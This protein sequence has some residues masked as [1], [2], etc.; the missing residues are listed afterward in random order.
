MAY[1]DSAGNYVEVGGLLPDR[2][3][4]ALVRVEP[5]EVGAA[6]QVVGAG[7]LDG[8]PGPRQ[9]VPR[10]DVGDGGGPYRVGHPGGCCGWYC[11][12]GCGW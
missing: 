1:L 7:D 11:W 3:V 2:V 6:A 5:G 8:D 4:E 12:V 9:A 10:D